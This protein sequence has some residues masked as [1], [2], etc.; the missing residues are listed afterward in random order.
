MEL[1]DSAGSKPLR[2][3]HG[4]PGSALVSNDHVPAV[5][6]SK[7]TLISEPAIALI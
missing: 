2:Q 1:R 7:K 6:S 3:P 4:R 5:N